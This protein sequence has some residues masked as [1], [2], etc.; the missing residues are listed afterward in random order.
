[1]LISNYKTCPPKPGMILI[2]KLT[3]FRTDDKFLVVT[4][5]YAADDL[6]VDTETLGDSDDFLRMFR[7]KIDLEAMTHVEHLVHLGP[8]GAALLMN[9]LEERRNREK[10][11]FDDADV[12]ADKMKNL[13][14][15]S[16]RAVYHSMNLWT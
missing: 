1:M 5:L 4:L 7:R 2:Y 14:L 6:S 11:V 3:E 15:S 13:G 16:T 8:I 12:V 9:G 10:I